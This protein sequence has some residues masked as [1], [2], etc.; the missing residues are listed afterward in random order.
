M[1]KLG[2]GEVQRYVVRSYVKGMEVEVVHAAVGPG[3][4]QRRD[5]CSNQVVDRGI[6]LRFNLGLDQPRTAST[7]IHGLI[8]G[9]TYHFTVSLQ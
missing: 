5:F 3:R 9:L 4:R 7:L 2:C 8:P 6:A 1:A